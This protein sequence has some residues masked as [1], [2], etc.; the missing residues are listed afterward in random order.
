MTEIKQSGFGAVLRQRREELGLSLNDLAASTRVRKTY[1]QA[2]EEENLQMLPGAAYAVG[3]LRIYARQLGL[4]V[5]SLIATL[6]ANETLEDH[7][8]LPSMG[9][10]L[11]RGARKG[12]RKKPLSRLLL[13]LLL[14]LLLLLAGGYLYFRSHARP[15]QA[16]PVA[17]APPEN[18]PSSQPAPQP[19]SR[20]SPATPI[21]ALSP[22]PGCHRCLR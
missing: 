6:A 9:G 18:S 1:L 3:F 4:P 19:G 11:P 17:V 2:L 7:P 14:C 13:L 5:E 8:A 16:T 15:P 10:D 22:A 21:R 20:R 12:R